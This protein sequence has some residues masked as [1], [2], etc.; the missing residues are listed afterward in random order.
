M[1][2]LDHNRQFANAPVE[3]GFFEQRFARSALYVMGQA[4]IQVIGGSLGCDL[5]VRLAESAMRFGSN[6]F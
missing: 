6:L 5:V 2:A 1:F 3:F 4:A